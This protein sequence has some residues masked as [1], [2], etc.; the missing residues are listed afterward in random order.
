[1]K[2]Y[3]LKTLLFTV[4]PMPLLAAP[5]LELDFS[6]RTSQGSY[7]EVRVRG[8]ASIKVKD[9]N[10]VR[11][12]YKIRRQV[13]AIDV[14]PDVL[15][16]LPLRNTL[17]PVI[18]TLSTRG[19]AEVLEEREEKPQTPTPRDLHSDISRAIRKAEGVQQATAELVQ[20]LRDFITDS[21]RFSNKELMTRGK[22]LLQEID[23]LLLTLKWPRTQ[24]LRLRLKLDAQGDPLNEPLMRATLDLID[25]AKPEWQ[26]AKNQITKFAVHLRSTQDRQ[27]E[28]SEFIACDFRPR[29]EV[30]T[31]L[32]LDLFPPDE[33]DE[34]ETEEARV[35]ELPMVTF[36]CEHPLSFSTGVFVSTLDEKEFAFRPMVGGEEGN[37]TA[38]DV[39]GFNNR[40]SFRMMP[41]VM[42]NMLVWQPSY[43]FDVRLSFGALAD[44]GGEQG[45]ALEF[46]AGPSFGINKSVL[47]TVGAHVGRVLDLQG[48]FK[49]GTPKIEGHDS[50]PTQKSYR[51]GLGFGISYNFKP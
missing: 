19:Q 40:S 44:F 49:I 23:D 11:Y 46:I 8:K 42:V 10:W 39:I 5:E 3:L 24:V 14:A 17:A 31:L 7:G 50:V 15:K 2:R 21:G 9:L 27:P 20:K 30:L 13:T 22:E 29:K 25:A 38:T 26:R 47:F 18:Q 4:F 6:A 32:V 43:S 36:V 41:G 37:P 35:K 16:I 28:I 33:A 1:M 51:V 34:K 48:G 12:Q 45:T